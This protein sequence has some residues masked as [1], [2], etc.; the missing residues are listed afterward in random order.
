[1]EQRVNKAPLTARTNREIGGRAPSE[2]LSRLEEK[3]GIASRQLDEILLSHLIEP[4]LL[5]TDAFDPFIQTRASALLDLIEQAT[6]KA[7][8]GRDSEEVAEAFGAGLLGAM[9]DRVG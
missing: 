5:R 2:Y 4:R 3:E 1:M 9:D 6:G 8:P 7:V